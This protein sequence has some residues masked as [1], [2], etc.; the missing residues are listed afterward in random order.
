VSFLRKQESREKLD[1]HFRGNDIQGGQKGD[2]L[3][4]IAPH[5][6]LSRQGRGEKDHASIR[7]NCYHPQK[8]MLSKH[9]LQKL[10][11]ATGNALAN[12][13]RMSDL[14]G[15]SEMVLRR[16]PSPLP[17]PFDFQKC[18]FSG[19]WQSGNAGGA[20]I[21]LKTEFRYSSERDSCQSISVQANHCLQED[22]LTFANLSDKSPIFSHLGVCWFCEDQ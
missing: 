5:P 14:R 9:R 22:I 2:R 20:E 19:G 6:T 12:P 17:N 8:T 21:W 11:M 4:M 1:S 15:C 10:T 7:L 18:P 13:H 3:L 16:R